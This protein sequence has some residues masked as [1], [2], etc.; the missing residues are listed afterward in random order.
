M[1]RHL[2]AIIL[3]ISM[4][5]GCPG[6]NHLG[7]CMLIE[8]VHEAL[9]DA[10]K[11][12]SIA[13]RSHAVEFLRKVGLDDFGL[14]LIGMPN[15]QY[16]K[17]SR[18]LPSM[19]SEKVQNEWT[20]SSGATLLMQTNTFIRFL[21]TSFITLTKKDMVNAKVLDFGCGYGRSIRSL[22]CYVDPENI[23][24]V[25]PW[26]LSIEQC[27][28]HG[29][30]G[31]IFQSDYLPEN[32]PFAAG[33]FDIIYAFSVF[34]HLSERATRQSLNTLRKYISADGV[35]MI[36]VRPIEYWQFDQNVPES[37]KPELEASHRS[38]GFAYCP[39]HRE[40]IDGDVT[41]GDTTIAV[42]W[43]QDNL[44][45]WEVVLLDRPLIDPYQ[46]YLALRPKNG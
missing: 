16:P 45:D 19:A 1:A 37:L 38:S 5:L 13:T 42:A 24:G 35:L 44:P 17:L 32:L 36:S 8:T 18:L 33:Q 23:S 31:N 7:N 2:L 9:A 6:H 4:R 3:I 21:A 20:G 27:V 30:S 12:K 28:L 10:E 40:P 25:D 14:I 29:I 43:L 39:H 41:Y 11:N 22:Y 46:I 26:N 34:T 15:T